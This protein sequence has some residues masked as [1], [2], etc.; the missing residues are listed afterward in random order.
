MLRIAICDKNVK[1]TQWLKKQIMEV[2][3]KEKKVKF[4]EYVNG[5]DFLEDLYVKKEPDILF[6]DVQMPDMDGYHIAVKLRRYTK[7]TLLIFCSGAASPAPEFFQL[8]VYRFLLKQYDTQRMK[9]ELEEILNNAINKKEESYLWGHYRRSYHKIMPRDVLYVSIAKRGS[10]IHCYNDL[11]SKE[12]SW[13][14]SCKNK[15]SEIYE[16]LKSCGF[17]YAHNSYIVN[18]RYV[19]RKN[20]KEV[21]LIDGTILSVSR[22]K[23]KLFE[24]ALAEYCAEYY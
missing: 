17:A 15:L 14:I 4:R 21:E 20:A 9:K 22:S 11:M 3:P 19:V 10:M 8:G 7:Y 23:T 12:N 24:K 6:L 2:V 13:E 18:M 16:K 1:Y 5:N